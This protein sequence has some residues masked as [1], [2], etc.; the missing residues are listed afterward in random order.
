MRFKLNV[1]PFC[2]GEAKMA[3]YKGS[4]VVECSTCGAA[5]R[6]PINR[7]D[8]PDTLNTR[9]EVMEAWNL[10]DVE[11]KPERTCRVLPDEAANQAM[12]EPAPMFDACGV[13]VPTVGTLCY[14]PSGE[15]K[16]THETL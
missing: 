4:W 8:D 10:R 6:L 7:N 9:D 12:R 1:C 2:G 3:K 15:T 14:C 13:L 11:S 5:I 16:V